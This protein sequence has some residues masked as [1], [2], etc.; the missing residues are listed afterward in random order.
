M[1]LTERRGAYHFVDGLHNR[2]HFLVADLAVPIDVVQLERPI[3]LI[4]HLPSTGNTQRAYEFLEI[5]GPALVRVE[6]LEDVVG[7]RV[8]VTER[9]ELSINLLEFL[10]G[11]SAR[12]TVLEEACMGETF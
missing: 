11:Q 2:E 4:L 9:E 8:R 5:N 10:F 6:H 12:G 1:Y 3:Q 7:E